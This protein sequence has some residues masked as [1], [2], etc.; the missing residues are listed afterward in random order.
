MLGGQSMPSPRTKEGDR[1][2]RGWGGKSHELQGA[3]AGTELSVYRRAVGKPCLNLK[4]GVGLLELYFN[5]VY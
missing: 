2:G 1:E 5:E 3:Q 4:R